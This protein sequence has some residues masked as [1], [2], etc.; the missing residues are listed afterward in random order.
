VINSKETIDIQLSIPIIFF[1][2]LVP[3]LLILLIIV[4]FSHPALPM[5][6]S[7]HLSIVLAFALGLVPVELGILK[8]FSR[9]E[10][11]KNIKD[12]IL[13][14][15]KTP[16][17]IFIPLIVITFAFAATVMSF[18]PQYEQKIWKI[19]DFVPDWFREETTNIIEIKYLG[20]TV[21]LGLLFDG[22]IVPIVEEIYFRGFLLPRM[23][24]FGRIAP[25]INVVLFSIYHFF[26]PWRN[27][28]RIISLIPGVY[29]I[30]KT[31]DIRIGII[32]HC[33]GNV[34]GWVSLI[35]GI[36]VSK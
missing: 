30:W 10:N 19:F 21:V 3:G 2:S 24:V 26:T 31:K 18:L 7:I 33:L 20:L 34:V 6:F 23:Q 25:L 36:I 35:I 1:L 12:L 22:I 8:Y 17:K 15:N 4:I 5:N 27:I 28:S 32:I 11:R 16:M 9:K 29:V 14:R 13:F